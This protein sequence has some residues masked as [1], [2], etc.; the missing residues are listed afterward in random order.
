MPT[1]LKDLNP[2]DNYIWDPDKNDWVSDNGISTGKEKWYNLEDAADKAG[3]KVSIL[4]S[5]ISRGSLIGSTIQKGSYGYRWM[6]SESNL[7]DWMEDPSVVRDPKKREAYNERQAENMRKKRGSSQAAVPK[8]ISALFEEHL[9]NS[10]D[11]GF[12]DGYAKAWKELQ[13]FIKEKKA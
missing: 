3:T 8:D 6:V 4:R 13:A 1:D 10:Y 7:K 5:A 2:N 11:K 9:K 12:A